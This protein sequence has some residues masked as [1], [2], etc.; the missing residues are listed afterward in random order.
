VLEG[1]LTRILEKEAILAV[2]NEKRHIKI[3]V[4][5]FL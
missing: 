3:K 2:N 1:T 4:P 5:A